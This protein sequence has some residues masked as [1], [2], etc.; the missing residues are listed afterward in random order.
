M[1]DE[2]ERENKMTVTAEGHSANLIL[3]G[4]SKAQIGFQGGSLLLTLGGA[5]TAVSRLLALGWFSLIGTKYVHTMWPLSTEG[6]VF[7]NQLRIWL[8]PRRMRLKNIVP[9]R[10]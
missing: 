7:H 9:K 6:P 3:I 2:R 8:G 4:L 1:E 10:P 5:C